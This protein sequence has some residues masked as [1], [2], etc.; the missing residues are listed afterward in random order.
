MASKSIEHM[1]INICCATI[2]ME[3]FRWGL[4]DEDRSKRLEA[5]KHNLEKSMDSMEKGEYLSYDEVMDEIE[6]KL[7]ADSSEDEKE[8]HRHK[9]E[10][11]KRVKDIEDRNRIKILKEDHQAFIDAVRYEYKNR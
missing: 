5:L 6:R 4:T 8:Y 2:I 10:F 1:G 11:R 3:M 9:K 7:Y